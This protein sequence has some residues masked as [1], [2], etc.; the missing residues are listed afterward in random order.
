V[1]W[2]VPTLF[3]SV[4]KLPGLS[5]TP[6]D[7]SIPGIGSL[8]ALSAEARADAGRERRA[9]LLVEKLICAVIVVYAIQLL[10]SPG[11]E[12][13]TAAHGLLPS[14]F[15]TGL[16]NEIFFYMPFAVLFSLLRDIRWTRRLLVQCVT[17]TAGLAVIF[18]VIGFAEW[19]SGNLLFNSKLE[20]LNQLHGYFAVTSVFF[21]PDIFGRYLALTMILMVA[22]LLYDR[23]PRIQLI[24]C[25]VLVVLWVCLIISFSRSSILALLLGM[26]VLAAMRWRTREILYVAGAI[27]L[28]GIVV[29][30]THYSTFVP[31]LSTASSGRSNLVSGGLHLF[32]QRPFTG[33]GSGS[34]THEYTRFYSQDARSVAD[35]HNI[36]VTILSEQGIIGILLYLAFVITALITLFRGAKG[37]GYRVAIAAAFVALLLHTQLYADFLED[38]TTWVLLAIGSALT[39]TGSYLG[40]VDAE[41]R[42]GSAQETGPGTP[43]LSA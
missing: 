43:A 2:A 3:P 27:V 35:S 42:P 30:A 33:W 29:V 19:F 12:Y 24:C 4:T 5:D 13:S 14:G 26:A 41:A 8:R 1:A 9:P 34:F 10:Y 38:P 11:R 15:T 6:P 31:N 21:D 16:Q 7:W 28:I 32:G 25:G 39:V 22:V 40:P 18:S 36:P 37:N 20:V 17:I 23:R